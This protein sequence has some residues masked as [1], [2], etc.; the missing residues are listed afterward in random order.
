MA[1]SMSNVACKTLVLDAGPLLMLS[2]LRGLAETFVTVPQ[3]LEELKDKRSREHFERLGLVAGVGVK[4]QSPDPV[5]LAYVIQFAKRTGDY[6]ALS[7]ADLCVLALTY[8][9]DGAE[10]E[11]KAQPD[12]DEPSLSPTVVPSDPP[13]QN[14]DDNATSHE[15]ETADNGEGRVVEEE[16]NPHAGI[17]SMDDALESI[18][19]SLE[20]LDV[21]LVPLNE[22]GSREQPTTAPAEVASPSGDPE[23]SRS[24]A[25]PFSP[26]PLYEDPLNDDDGEGEWITPENIS[27]HKAR[28]LGLTPS[29]NGSG[30]GRKNEIIPV[31]CMTADFA[32]QNVL[33][34][35]DLSLVGMEGKRIERV[36]TWVLRCHG[37]F[38]ICKDASKKFCPSCGNPT[39]LRA[40][41]TISSPSASSAAPAMQVH[42]KK[43][44]QYRKRGTIYSIPAPKPGSA[45]TGSGEGLILREDQTEYMRATKRAET[46][47]QREEKKLLSDA[48]ASGGEGKLGVGNWM[49]PDWIPELMTAGP[50]GKGRNSSR[51]ADGMPTIGYG[52]RNPNE[53]RRRK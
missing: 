10:R 46:Q 4:V 32:M 28:A 49:D 17:K 41:V 21:E 38:K 26:P 3:V 53:R 45:K 14:V 20:R 33:L 25:P 16:E 7:H 2:P 19:Q 15:P 39:L 51:Q 22:D 40:S 30:R 24:D 42:L 50:T 37:C 12:V 34:Q 27:L 18:E 29:E 6:S 48:I 5:S 31:G 13:T 1:S 36:K 44:F 47:R 23:P 11:R 9:L 52:K 35:M 43:N 8:A